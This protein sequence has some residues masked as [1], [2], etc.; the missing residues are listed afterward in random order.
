MPY[1]SGFSPLTGEPRMG[2]IPV[3]TRIATAMTLTTGGG[4]RTLTAAE[5]LGGVLIVNCDDAQTANL[6]TG[7]LLNAALPGCSV[8]ASFELDVVN[9]GDTTLTIAVG[10]GGTL[11][12]G[13]SKS[14]V[15]T[16]VAQASKR[17]VIIVTGVTQ[18]GDASDAYQ[19]IGMGS[20][21]ASNA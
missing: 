20:I 10:T 11:V 15:A 12:Q 14:T 7:T 16:I 5:V 21:A 17:F 2:M 6:P 19:V 1:G 3:P 18:N 8:G 4:V 9:V 13:N